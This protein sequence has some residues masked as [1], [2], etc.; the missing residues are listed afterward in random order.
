M[1]IVLQRNPST[2]LSTTGKLSIDGAFFCFTLEDVVREFKIPTRTAIPA[3][4]YAVEITPSQR[5]GRDMPLVCD[6]PGFS[7]IRI[8]SGNTDKDTDG[9]I[10]LGTTIESDD[11][12]GNSRAAFALFYTR[13]SNAIA[14][15]EDVT[16][17]VMDARA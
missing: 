12:V 9:C 1:E 2:Q 14:R 4:T 10:L 11:F 17:Q 3:G 15:G 13:L 7:G 5:F 16:L 6:V 8:H